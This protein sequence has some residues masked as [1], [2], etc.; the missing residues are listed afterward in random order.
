VRDR[1][2]ERTDVTYGNMRVKL[3]DYIGQVFECKA[4]WGKRREANGKGQEKQQIVDGVY[5]SPLAP[6]PSPL[7]LLGQSRTDTMNHA[8]NDMTAQSCHP[9]SPDLT[10]LDIAYPIT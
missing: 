5:F 4:A 8:D 2:A 10:F 9:T 3:S 7:A 6:C 1:R